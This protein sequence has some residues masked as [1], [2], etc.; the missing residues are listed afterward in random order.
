VIAVGYDADIAQARS[1]IEAVVAAEARVARMPAPEVAVQDILPTAVALAVRV[2]V[3]TTDY[4]PVRS[5]LLERIK[6]ALDKYELS[7]P[8]AQ[9]V[10][11][12]TQPQPV[13]K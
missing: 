6:R 8:A 11:P 2:W 10:L 7:I 13:S 4:G 5:D 3:T 1:V 9:R 12:W